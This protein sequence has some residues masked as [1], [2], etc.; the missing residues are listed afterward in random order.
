MTIRVRL[1]L[2]F[3]VVVAILLLLFILVIYAV[4]ERH[5]QLEFR[6]RLREEAQTAAE[7]MLGKEPISP[8]L[9]KLLDQHQMTVLNQEEVIIYNHRNTITYESGTDY[10]TVSPQVLAQVRRNGDTY[11]QAGNREV[12]GIPFSINGLDY[13]AIASAV[14]K[15]GYSKQRNLALILII[16]WA[17]GMG[18]VFAAGWLF[19]GRSLRPLQY[20]ISRIDA[21]TASQ[22]NLRLAEGTNE[23]EL[24]Q[25]ARRFNR[26]LDRLEEAFQM[27]RAFVANASHELRT[28]LT[29]ITGQLDV[30]LL[31]NDDDPQELR[32]LIASVL[33]DVRGLNRMTNNLLSLAKLSLDEPGE[34]AAVVPVDVLLQQINVDLLRMQPTYRVQIELTAA[35][36]TTANWQITA[37]EALLRSAL[38][39]LMENGGKFSPDQQVYCQLVSH[40]QLIQI[41][42]TNY[43]PCIPADELPTIFKPFRRGTN[44]RQISGHGIGL[45]LVE[46]IVQL[47][48]GQVV[49]EST[50]DNGT[51]FTVTLPR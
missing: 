34:T 43:G 15:Y 50:P 51:T 30:A 19:A 32:A 31:A 27:Q 2:L 47:H 42:F 22:L 6:E 21:T 36:G 37:N 18:V 5:R 9:F 48:H 14:D 38:Y 28:P 46:R 11:W 3:T 35:P 29:A 44:A 8:A 24:T 41:R 39:N 16:G 20:I 12:V 4:S 17:L 7:L 33:D 13:V 49:A 10:L 23:D 1:T 40:A 45:S 26:M 25:L